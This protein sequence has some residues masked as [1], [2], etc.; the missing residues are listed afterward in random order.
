MCDFE[1][2]LYCGHLA[3]LIVDRTPVMSWCPR[4]SLNLI[5]TD[6]VD[7]C[8]L[9]LP[10]DIRVATPYYKPG[11]NKTGRHPV[12]KPILKSSPVPV[13]AL[14]IINHN[15][16]EVADSISSVEGASTAF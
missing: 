5:G 9:I 3:V 13:C 11:H 10:S 14:P 7:Q 15:A 2:V 12:S 16:C 4:P 6:I 8:V 1:R